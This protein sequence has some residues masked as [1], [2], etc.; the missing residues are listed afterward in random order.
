MPTPRTITFLPTPV[1]FEDYVHR[2]GIYAQDQWTTHRLTMN[3]GVR[4]DWFTGGWPAGEAHPALFKTG[5]PFDA[6]QAVNWKDLSP[7]LGLAY[8][9]FGN[10]G[11]AIKAGLSRFVTQYSLDLMKPTN[12]ASALVGNSVRNW[13]DSGCVQ[14]AGG[15]VSCVA[16]DWVPQGDPL[17]PAAN[18]EL[19]VAANQSFGT[20]QSV[21]SFD[22]D[23]TKAYGQRPYT[24]HT[25]LGIDHQLLPNF[26]VRAA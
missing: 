6:E 3:Y 25:T 26:S 17:N 9:V 21:L 15:S 2:T 16:G 4:F 22:Q 12:P 11:T 5:H 18:G 10:G 19:G 8:D 20:Y 23:W 13:T 1:Y 24:W 14:P 7:R